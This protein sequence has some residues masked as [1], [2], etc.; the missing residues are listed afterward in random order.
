MKILA[1]TCA[2]FFTASGTELSRNINGLQLSPTN[3][4]HNVNP[5][6][7]LV[8]TFPSPPTIGT[9]GT[10]RVYDTADNKLVDTLD[11]SIPS[12]PSPYGNGSTKANYSDI[13][14]YQ[15][16]IIGGMDFYFHPIIVRGNVGTVYL[17]NNQL[18]YGRTYSVEMDA[19]FLS[20][21]DG[22]FEGI[23]KNSWAFSTKSHGPS[24][25]AMQVVV[26]ADG[27]ADFNTVQGAIDW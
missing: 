21:A 19:E 15:T 3:G 27:S 25:N 22:T 23:T 4:Q 14:T 20:L 8:L 17:H 5:D 10:I 18:D 9:N 24:P 16:N 7:H 12:S 13:T 1:V 2:L 11:L 6:T 26:A